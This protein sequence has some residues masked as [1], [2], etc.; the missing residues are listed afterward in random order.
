MRECGSN[1]ALN[2]NLV[3]GEGCMS[4]GICISRM[5]SSGTDSILGYFDSIVALSKRVHQVFIFLDC[6]F[7]SSFFITQAIK[8][9]LFHI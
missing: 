5:S 2:G 4:P 7:M 6:I 8:S 1:I 3:A 9:F